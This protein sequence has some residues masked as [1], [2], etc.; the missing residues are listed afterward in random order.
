MNQRTRP[1]SRSSTPTCMWRAT[2]A[3]ASPR[4]P[5]GVGSQ[6][7]SQPDGVGPAVGRATQCAGA[8][9]V[10]VV[11]EVGAYDHDCACASD[12]VESSAGYASLVTSVDMTAVDVSRSLRACAGWRL[13]G[14][15]DG[16]PWLDDERAATSSGRATPIWMRSSSRRTSPTD[17]NRWQPQRPA[18]PPCASRSIIARLRTWAARRKAGWLASRRGTSTNS[19]DHGS[20][21]APQLSSAGFRR[22]ETQPTRNREHVVP[23]VAS[24]RSGF[25][26]A[27]EISTFGFVRGQQ[28]SPVIGV[29][30]CVVIIRHFVEVPDGRVVAVMAAQ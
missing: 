30:R 29:A 15:G 3:S 4:R 7:W 10:V 6:W 13:F 25:G 23:A 2:T 9:H 20:S 12:V 19:D 14:V 17:W 28:R 1:I 24:S 22:D 8:A 27:A 18:T 16:A 21:R 11:Q 5:T 26:L